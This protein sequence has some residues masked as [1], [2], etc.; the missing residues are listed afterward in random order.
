MLFIGQLKQGHNTYLLL[1]F[2]VTLWEMKIEQLISGFVPLFPLDVAP[3]AG[4]VGFRNGLSRQNGLHGLIQVFSRNGEG[5]SGPARV[6]L[7]AIGESATGIE[8]EEVWSAGSVIRTRHCLG[9]IEE[10]G[11]GIAKGLYLLDHPFRRVV[12]IMFRVIGVDGNYRDA[13]FL[14]P[15]G[16]L[17]Q[18]FPYVMDKGAMVTDKHDKQSLI[19][20]KI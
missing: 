10:V 6:K 2:A 11:E 9:F 8:E 18:P 17:S 20:G 4:A 16:K 14:P 13:L 19:F 3:H 15:G 5:I 7:A 1:G 12:G